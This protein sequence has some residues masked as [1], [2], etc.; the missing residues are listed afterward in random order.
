MSI[1]HI[2]SCA[3]VA[4]RVDYLIVGR[5]RKK[6]EHLRAGTDRMAAMT[7]DAGSI[8]MFVRE[9]R[10][11]AR[12]HSRRIEAM[13]LI[14]SF[15]LTEFNPTNPA[16]VQVANDLGWELAHRRYASSR[17]LVITHTD[18]D[19]HDGCG[20]KVHNHIVVLNHDEQTGRAITTQGKRHYDVARV[21]DE[22]MLEVGLSVVEPGTKTRD[23]LEDHWAARRLTEG[24]KAFDVELGDRIDQALADPAAIDWPSYV[25]ILDAAGVEVRTEDRDVSRDSADVRV[26]TGVTYMMLDTTGPKQRIRRRMASKLSPDFMHQA[27]T[28]RLAEKARQVVTPSSPA[29]LALTVS[30]QLHAQRRVFFAEMNARA[31]VDR[32]EFRRRLAESS[33]AIEIE[34]RRVHEARMAAAFPDRAEDQPAALDVGV[35]GTPDIP[36]GPD[37]LA[38]AGIEDA[39]PKPLNEVDHRRPA[40]ENVAPP[41]DAARPMGGPE[42]VFSAVPESAPKARPKR[43]LTPRQRRLFAAHP[44][45]DPAN[46]DTPIPAKSRPQRDHG[47]SLG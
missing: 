11:L 16:D 33:T 32:S 44:G 47:P 36:T 27:V 25:E 38:T 15:A 18:G 1:T 13:T 34:G 22:L 30:E 29:A 39:E 6:R 40:R 10:S 35:A 12:R 8:R 45:L 26:M 19:G 5:G 24:V 14:Q 23:N 37:D 21:N 7:C 20:A 42:P 4:D 43:E 46:Q 9:A 41:E 28:E 31:E 17:C 2:T 3:D